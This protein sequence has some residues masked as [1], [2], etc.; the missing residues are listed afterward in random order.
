[1]NLD[2][3]RKLR[4]GQRNGCLIRV[5]KESFHPACI[6]FNSSNRVSYIQGLCFA[7]ARSSHY[8]LMCS[9][10]IDL[11]DHFVWKPCRRIYYGA[12]R[13]YGHWNLLDRYQ[14]S[15]ACQFIYVI[16]WADPFLFSSLIKWMK[17]R[18]LT[19]KMFSFTRSNV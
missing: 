19:N 1:M 11:P 13:I 18:L 4:N 8:Q 17:R 6:D 5:R 9:R 7:R 14:T 3:D 2:W 16:H 12:F 10:E 15:I